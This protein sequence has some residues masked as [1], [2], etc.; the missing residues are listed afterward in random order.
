MF[1]R[2]RMYA[3]ALVV[4][5]LTA[6]MAPLTVATAEANP[7]FTYYVG[8]LGNSVIQSFNDN[9]AYQAIQERTGVTLE[10]MH[11]G[12][13]EMNNQLGVMIASLDMPDIMELGGYRYPKG[14]D[15]MIDDGIIYRLNELVEEYA[16]DYF[17]LINSDPEIRRQVVTDEGNIWAFVCIQPTDETCWRGM[18]IRKDL[19]DAHGK[20]L[21]ETIAEFKECLL[22]FQE[23]G[24]EIPFFF[25]INGG[26]FDD[27]PIVSAYGVGPM[28]YI[29]ME[30]NTM[31]FGPMEDGYKAFLTEMHE[32][33]E[34][35][36][37]DKEA[38][39][40]NGTDADALAAAGEIGVY[41][42][43]GYGP[44]L[45]VNLNGQAQN[46]DFLLYPIPNL[47]LEKGDTVH[48]KNYNYFNKGEPTVIPTTCSDPVEAVK[49][50]NF[51]YTEEGFYLYNY[52][53]EGVSWEMVDGKPEFTTLITEST[54][55]PWTNIREKYKRHQGP[56]LRDE[57]AFPVTDFEMTCMEEWSK[58]GKEMCP[59]PTSLT[60]AESERY[61][62]FWPD[63][64]TYVR[65]MRW[66]FI[67]GEE[68]L[69]NYDAFRAQLVAMGIEEALEIQNAALVRYYAR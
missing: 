47:P 9:L 32:W 11:S 19:L 34:L 33:Y 35:G 52:G 53:V 36:L 38:P 17:A 40:R 14:A 29:D 16:P 42:Q 28:Y 56:Y 5:L 31:K 43:A 4:I 60:A 18:S 50:M 64:N 58:P 6:V 26:G 7:T 48:F 67:T 69:D 46:P 2:K 41:L 3:L 57:W 39:V 25:N 54:E 59:L 8:N 44:T 62:Q 15:A 55:G 10:F 21:P 1:Q 65:E 45:A 20:A 66:K 63:I 37:L 61:A 27:G 49:F 24:L 13:G 12:L 22:F 51:G 68:S 23:L 30:T